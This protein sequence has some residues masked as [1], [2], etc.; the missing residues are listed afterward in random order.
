MISFKRFALAAVVAV[1]GTTLVYASPAQA[2]PLCTHY[3]AVTASDDASKKTWVPATSGGDTSCTLYEGVYNN[4]AVET[5]QSALVEC[6]AMNIT[7]DGDFGPATKSALKQVQSMI[8][9]TSDGQYGVYT[10]DRIR[11]QPYTYG[12]ICHKYNGPGGY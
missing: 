7:V 2:L 10:R 11:H 5:L 8:G 3:K 12:D 4:M 9:V 6:Y 1:F